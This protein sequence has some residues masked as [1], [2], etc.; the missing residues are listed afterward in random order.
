MGPSRKK[1]QMCFCS[2]FVCDASTIYSCAC[3]STCLVYV[4]EYVVATGQYFGFRLGMCASMP[5][6]WASSSSLFPPSEK[7]A[8][9]SSF[10]DEQWMYFL[11]CI[12]H[13]RESGVPCK[14]TAY[15]THAMHTTFTTHT[16]THTHTQHTL[17]YTQQTYYHTHTHTHT[18][19]QTQ[20]TH[21]HTQTQ[22]PRI[23]NVQIWRNSS[24]Q[25]TSKS[26]FKT[27]PESGNSFK[28]TKAPKPL[29]GW[30][31]PDSVRM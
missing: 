17:P 27:A 7:W 1:N 26:T 22:S 10:L 25:Q 14:H 19:T 11:S 3:G 4:T 18:H 20:H 29:G 28:S 21:T 9:S 6:I 30:G 16:H 15:I 12:T 5:W 13:K 23:A 31:E 2:N 8:S 24:V